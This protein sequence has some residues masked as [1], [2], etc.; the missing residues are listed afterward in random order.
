MSIRRFAIAAAMAGAML[1]AP[2]LAAQP[3]HASGDQA[4]DPQKGVGPVS[5]VTLKVTV[6]I[7]R[8]EGEK[9]IASAPY[10]LMVVPSYGNNAEAGRDGDATTVQ[11][12]SET[13]VPVSEVKDGKPTTSINYRNL[14]TNIQVQGRPVDEGRYNIYVSVQDTQLSPAPAGTA[15]QGATPRYTTFRS[16]NRLT[17]RDSQTSQYAVATDTITGQVVKL[18]V[19]MNVVK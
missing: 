3:G 2:T 1:S 7:S 15:A 12:G 4:P 11:M 13:P 9:K 16:I 6:T 10:I 14:G 19:T 17:L 18:D 8:W 5:A